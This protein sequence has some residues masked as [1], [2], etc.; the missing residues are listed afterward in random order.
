MSSPQSSPAVAVPQLSAADRA[1]QRNAVLAGFLGWTFDAF[2]FFLLVMVLEG[3]AKDFHKPVQAIAL[4]LT[5]T[6]AMRPVGAFLFGVVADRYGR[7]LPLMLDIVFYSVI[8]VL[9]GFAPNYTTFF[10]LRMLYGIGMGGEWGV[11]ASLALESVPAKWRGVLSGLLQE[12]YA[13]GYL[14]AAAVTYYVYP[15]WG[16]RP[17]FFIGGLPALL[18]LFIRAKVKEPEAWQQSRTTFKEYS[19]QVLRNWPRFLYLVLL[20]MCMNGISHGTQDLYPTFLK[21]QLH[22]SVQ[23]ASM[24]TVISMVGAIL[25]GLLVGFLSDRMGRRKAMVM[26]ICFALAFIPLWVLVRSLPAI[27]F[28]AFLM[29]FMIQGAWGVIPAHINELS[30]GAARGFFPGFA[31]QVGVFCAS[32]I[33]YLESVVGEHMSYSQSLTYS[34]LVVMIVGALVVFFG[35]EDKGVHFVKQ[36]G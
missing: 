28:G 8:E 22:F 30:P 2:D 15:R 32:G 27:I 5:A 35:P 36:D 33:S 6:L 29:Q 14:L 20:M 1:S 19:S 18:T 23:T 10:I 26:A 11:G 12:G 13:T 31:Y 24:V 17:M 25:G 16:W 34:M 9:T 7:R 4:T 3:V 21:K